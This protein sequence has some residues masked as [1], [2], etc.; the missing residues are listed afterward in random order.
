MHNGR[1]TILKQLAFLSGGALILWI[2]LNSASVRGD[3]YPGRTGMVALADT[4]SVTL[5]NMDSLWAL[6][7]RVGADSIRKIVIDRLDSDSLLLSYI[8]SLAADTNLRAIRYLGHLNPS[9]RTA[10]LFE[11]QRR[12][13]GP[14]LF[15]GW[16]HE[17]ELDSTGTWYTA[18]ERVAG[19]NVRQPMRVTRSQYRQAHLRSSM[20]RNWREL[21]EIRQNR[22]ESRRRGGLGY[23]IVV[24]GGRESS[25]ATIFGKNEVDL[26]V[27]G[28]AEIRPGFD[29]QKNAQQVTLGRGSQ[30]NPS[31]DMDLTLGVTGTI[32]DKMQVSVDWDT[33]RSFD[34]ENQLKLQ[35]TGYEDEIIQSIE[36]GNVFL[37]TPSTLIRGGQSLF[38]IKSELQIGGFR[39]TTVMSQQEGQSNQL[40]LEGGAETT[41]FSRRATE[42][43]ERRHYFLSYY[44]RNRWEEAL[45]DPPNIILDAV[46]SQITDV[47][48]WKLQQVAPEEQ[49]VRQVV[50]MV[51]LGES[52]E[53]VL[54]ADRYTQAVRPSN[55]IDQYDPA[56]IDAQLRDG[57]AVPQ[58]YLESDLM[59]QPLT[60]SDYQVGQFRKLEPG[61][62]YDIDYAL[63]YVSLR[64]RIQESEA[65]AVSYRYL[66]SGQQQQVG[67]FSSETGGGDNSQT[68]DRLVL[69]LLKPV[70]LQQP[71]NIGQANQS[72]P[73]AWYLEMRN[74]YELDRGLLPTEFI[75]DIAHEPSGRASTR[76][77]PGITGQNTLIQVL[78]LDRL[79]ED[80]APKPDNLFDFLPNYS[81]KP[82]EG[83][84]VF[85]YLEPFGRRMSELIDA[86]G[87]SPADK[88]A[89]KQVYVFEDLYRTKQINAARNTRLNVYSLSGSYKGGIPSFYDLKAYSGVVD[90]SVRVTAGD[91][92]LTEGTD[93][94]VDYLGGTVTITNPAHLAGGRQIDIEWEENALLTLQKKTLLGAR[95]D[96]SAGTRFTAGGTVMRMSQ[97]SIT[98]KFRVGDEPISNMVW[99]L[100]GKVH[101]EPRWLTRA[102]DAVPLLQTKEASRIVI[103]GEFAQLRPGHTVTNA[104]K[105]QRRTLRS[106]G[107]DF[108]SDEQR[109]I[110]YVDDFEGFE[111]L[112]SLSRPGAWRLSSA[113]T[114]SSAGADNASERELTNDGRGGLGWYQLNQSSLESFEGGLTPAVQLL[115]PQQVFPNRESLQTERVLTTLDFYFSP[116]ERGPYNYNMDLGTF[117]DNP[118]LVW[119]GVTQRLTEGNTDFTAKNIEFVEFIF[120][121]FVEAGEA[122]PEARLIIDIGRISEDVI[123]DNKLNTEDGLSLS[124]PGSIGRLARLSTGQQNQSIN[125][126]ESA[127]RITEDLGIDGLASFPDN[128]FEREG[129]LGTEQVAFAD[130]LNSLQ[131]TTSSRYPQELAREIAKARYDPSADDYFH[132]LDTHFFGNSQFYPNGATIQERF[133]RFFSGYELNTFDAQQKLAPGLSGNGNTRVPDTEDTN[134]NSASDTDNSYFQYEVPLSLTTLDQLAQPEEVNDYVIN[135]I[136]GPSGATGWYL[137]RIPVRDFTGRVG[138]I[139]DF[140]LIESIRLW[141]TGHTSPITLRFATLE[142]VGSQWRTSESVNETTLD[143]EMLPD[144]GNSLFGP[145]ISIESVN[146]EENTVYEI[147]KSAV[148]SR[149]REP[150]SGTVRDAREQSMVIR[151]QDLPANRQMAVFRTYQTP[152]DLLRYEHLRMFL[153]MHGFMDETPIQPED[154]E[155]VRFFMRLGGNET[156]DY[157]EYEQP[158]TASP[159]DR[160]PEESAQKS[161]Y[162][163]RTSE[164]GTDGDQTAFVD[165]NSMNI[166]LSALNQIKFLRDTFMDEEGT[167]FDPTEVFWS[168]IHT[169]LQATI[170][171]FAAP[172]ARIGVRGTPSLARISTIVMG[173]RNGA[174]EEHILSDVNVWV[175]ELRVSGYDE[176]P[177]TAAVLNADVTLADFGS[178]RGSARM[179]TDGFGSLSS[180]L[181]ERDQDNVRNWNVNAQVNLDNFMPE[182]LGWSLPVSAN[183]RENTVIP[184]F[185]PNRGDIRV[186]SLQDAVEADSTLSPE[187]ITRRQQEISRQAQTSNSTASYSARIGKSGSRSR[188]LRHTLDGLSL[189]YSYSLAEARSP[190]Q[191]FRNSTQWSSTLAYR[192]AIRRPRVLRLFQWLD[193][194]PVLRMISHLGLNYLPSS[195]QYSL[196]ANRNYSESKQ[197]PDPVR[198]RSSTLPVD[199][200]FPL[201]PQ[202]SFNH[203]RQ[204]SFQYNP[205]GFLNFSAETSTNQSLNALGV[206]TLYSV[207]LVDSLGA[208]SVLSNTSLADLIAD[209][210]IDRSQVGISAFELA[211]LS[212]IRSDRVLQRAVGGAVPGGPSVRTESYTSRFNG[213]FR[214]RLTRHQSLNWLQFQDFSYAASFSWNNGSVSN[215]TGAR[216]STNVNLRAGMI[217]RPRTLLEQFD[218]YEALQASA[219]AAQ[220]AADARRKDRQAERQARRAARAAALADTTEAPPEDEADERIALEAADDTTMRRVTLPPWLSPKALFRKV[221][222]GVTSLEELNVSYSGTR[223][224]SGTNV[225]QVDEEGEVAVSYSLRDAVFDG[226]GPSLR[227][228]L[229]LDRYISAEQRV[230]N[231]RL[232]V[233]DALSNSDRWQARTNLN[234]STALRINLN[235]TLENTRREQLTY[236]VLEDGLP[237]AD[238]T[239]AGDTR[240]SVW[241]FGASYETMFNRH[242]SLWETDCAEVCLDA[243]TLQ[244]G[245][246][247]NRVIFAD[248]QA[249]YLSFG[250]SGLL[251]FPLPGWTVSYSG[252]SNWPLIRWLARSA[253]LRHNYGADISTDFRSNLRGGEPD[254]F[255]LA[256][257]PLIAFEIPHIEVD[258]ARINERFQPLVAVDMSFRG[259]IQTSV[260]WNTSNIFALSTTNNVVT[261]TS[262]SELSFTASYSTTGLRLPFVSRRLSNRLNFSLTLSRSV[263]DD[264]SYFIR[265]AMEAA[266]SEPDFDFARALEEPFVD[267]LT[268]TTR[269]QAR[270]RISYQFSNVL[271]A[272][273]YVQYEDFIGDSRRLPYTSIK[274]GFNLRVN[275]AH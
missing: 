212:L 150:Q 47:E 49:N 50:A 128:K 66:A 36:A 151:V 250:S 275:F 190:T 216:T 8:D 90:G 99:G 192:L 63:G 57:N 232:Q 58:D 219:R 182:R 117:M 80:G 239:Q 109:G 138:E 184:R 32:G 78:G 189:N 170:D 165:V 218:F 121:P 6:I 217:V 179:Q 12:S 160:L 186:T 211:E 79:N 1:R 272:D 81:I 5:H 185:D 168:D 134:Q 237:G 51:D 204:F 89:A 98:D 143:G 246:L 243:D 41:E 53:L 132:F 37:Q 126:I 45:S 187:E 75:L 193:G 123:P 245:V 233:V 84:L 127:D 153:H 96:Y 122:D 65:L 27:N 240:A 68:G 129:G 173:I 255:R 60:S 43:S 28:R 145:Q 107:R 202:H 252:I 92:T 95:L 241:A 195:L 40:S 208:E 120:R 91:I 149:I 257:G 152:Q 222:L 256:D 242:L 52:R 142:F 29:Y 104:F 226:R 251:P 148:R 56:E 105:D 235:W 180:T 220:T 11:W 191:Q 101:L 82:G 54:Q 260:A 15:T 263:N 234:P 253:T 19:L 244:S 199:V 227:Y 85:P 262:T 83:I 74:L 223:S 124:E 224:S 108:T 261:E 77:L 135:E 167:A 17:V 14:G 231:E 147:P 206:D 21:I 18:Y 46:F 103:T 7:T 203:A 258:A 70:N 174:G 110:S 102:I 248:F 230:I 86:S 38:G 169:S 118:R 247:T 34:F 24:P 157:Y 273:M 64:Q 213:T 228:R 35:Y 171:E 130:F 87:L 183:L 125:P 210:T 269:L 136:A 4:D 111:N 141:T 238:T 267:I 59:D 69:K 73:A 48:V 154:R 100:D 156:L 214:P 205:F 178:V 236:R 2:L 97:K 164:P 113:P 229:G 265:R 158:L 106:E 259:N 175:N 115:A 93:Y 71:A 161:D 225:G 159:L 162:L 88:Q 16:Q 194:V 67:D 22:R 72:N 31:F 119:G 163:W 76:T 176:Q 33:G 23:S 25:F 42:Y 207:I 221:F 215:N 55:D 112:F 274:G 200:Q 155:A 114:R 26:R 188:L 39:L 198:Q 249:S 201:R 166:R 271:T 94:I 268:S 131:S 44:F 172:G 62:H 137:V 116:H 140:T 13:F 177:G 30:L 10:S 146:N 197:R 270:P 196:R 9:G 266:I 3:Y 209:G 20:E 254:V 181:A 264:R 61:R 144:E 133:S 139:Q